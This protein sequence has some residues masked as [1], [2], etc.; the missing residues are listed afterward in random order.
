MLGCEF[1]YKLDANL[2]SIKSTVVNSNAVSTELSCISLKE[3]K[4][5][6]ITISFH[7]P[8]SFLSNIKEQK[9]DIKRPDD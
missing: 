6:Q 9:V 5:L 3:I 7:P 4:P 2:F 8:Y 1:L